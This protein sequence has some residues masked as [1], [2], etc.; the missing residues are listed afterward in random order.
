MITVFM[1]ALFFERGK[2]AINTIAFSALVILLIYPHSL[3]QPSFQLT[4]MSVLFIIICSERFYPMFKAQNRIVKWFASSALMT[5]A[6]TIGAMPVAIYHFY[7]I[8]PFSVIHNL[9]AVPPMCIVAMPVSLLGILLPWGEYLLRASGEMVGLPIRILEYLNMGYIYPVIRPT[10]FECVLYFAVVLSLIYF[11]KRIVLAGL[12]FVLLPLASGYSWYAYHERFHNK[13]LC[14]HFI[15]VG[16]GDA[17]LV[18][19][20][21][22]IRM[23]VDGGGQ[24]RGNYDIG[25]SVIT[26]ILLSR[27]IRTLD[28]VINTHPHSDHV[29][30]LFTV[31]KS[32]K[33]GHFVTGAYFGREAAFID[34]LTLL[35]KK[36]VPLEIWKK[37]ERH[38]LKGDMVVDVLNPVRGASSENPNNSSLV[39]K[40]TYRDNSFLLTGDIDREIEEKLILSGAPLRSNILK[41]PHHGSRFSSSVPFVR[42]VMPD[43][44]I[45][46]VGKGIKG[47]PGDDALNVYKALSIPV[48][49]T[50]RDGLIEICSDGRRLTCKVFR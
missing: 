40:L 37:G 14:V 23:L 5:V 43:M 13:T 34:L 7:G 19:A 17:M 39:L 25:K 15:D 38:L 4:F 46:S 21:A 45:L 28:C 29:G 44:A 49:R 10:L 3:F 12:I 42:T 30:G 26:P 48:A 41:I 22:G 32:F 6:A 11:S 18:E 1:L 36:G 47:L 20:P 16:L 9:I 35:K 8:N 2:H 31:L 50:D 24:L 33:V 27:K